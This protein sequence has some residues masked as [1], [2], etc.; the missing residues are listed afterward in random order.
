MG[1]QNLIRPEIIKAALDQVQDERSFIDELLA[2]TL[3]WE[4]PDGTTTL[5][6]ITYEWPKDDRKAPNVDKKLVGGRV[7]EINLT[8]TAQHW[9]VFILEFNDLK[10]FSAE[11][12]MTGVLREVLR[13]L[14]PNRRKAPDKRSW[15]RDH[16]LF[17]CTHNYKQFRFAYFKDPVKEKAPPRLAAFGWETGSSEV[18]TVCEFNLTHLGWPDDPANKD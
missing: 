10:V 9:G 5:D 16:L 2:V 1:N 7:L 3:N 8:G 6:E 18:R 4:I 13:W 15:N 17:I 14:V 12:G 11:R